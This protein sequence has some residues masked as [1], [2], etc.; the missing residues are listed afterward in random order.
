MKLGFLA[1][2]PLLTAKASSVNVV[3]MCHAWAETGLDVTLF[4]PRPDLDGDPYAFYGVEPNFRIKWLSDHATRF[5]RVVR[6]SRLGQFALWQQSIDLV[7][8]RCH[9]MEPYK[10]D[11]L[12]RPFIIEAHTLHQGER[13]RA[14]LR[15]PNLRG[16][17]VVNEELAGEMRRAHDLGSLPVVVARSAAD[18]VPASTTP[19]DLPGNAALRCGYIGNLYAGKGMELLVPLAA[20]CPEVDFHVFGGSRDDADRFRSQTG[21]N[22]YVHGFLPPAEAP[23]A[24]RACN[25][26]LA[27]YQR[28][29]HGASGKT[30]LSRW[31][32]PLKLVEYMA[33][34]RAIIASDL[35]SIRE[36]VT[37]EETALVR[38]ADDVGAWAQAT[39]RL[40][41][42][43]AL[44]A[45]LGD[46][47]Q[48]AFEERHSWTGR[49]LAMNDAFG[50]VP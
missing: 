33:A 15:N 7:W 28:R 10:L 21:A 41:T 50:L 45:R 12:R 5:G 29:V 26:L 24:M 44:R 11:R 1:H 47:A 27:P 30:D 9:A 20:A 6:Q 16:L 42:D 22:V 39:R 37:D 40:L 13:F 19:L 31:M 23:R 48:R 34:G 49:A 2:T 36:I 17:A 25:V 14:I 3:K 38:P 18:P 8:A 46:A 32:S 4:C 43:D 35:A